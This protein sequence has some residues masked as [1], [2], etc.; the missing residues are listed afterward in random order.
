MCGVL[1]VSASGYYAWLRRGESRRGRE[2]RRLVVEIKAI[3]REKYGVYGSPRM[4]RE[5]RDRGMRHGKKRV[6]RLMRENGIM[7]KQ[8]KKF[9]AT[10]DSKHS[11]PV[12]PNLLLRNFEAETP[13]RKWLADITYIPTGEGWLYLA[14]ILDLHSR[15]LVGW[16]MSGRI[17]KELVLEA[18]QMAVG[19]RRPMSGLIHHSDRGSQYACAQY[20]RELRSQGIICSMSKTGDCWDN[21]PME[22]WFH[23]LK[24]ELVNHRDYRTRMQAKADIFEYIELFYNRSRK[25]SALGYMTPAQYEI[26]KMAA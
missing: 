11:H 24:T 2:D 26:S 1:E 18:L 8:K 25:H 5:L 21:A 22:S 6:A 7:A 13:D 19:R 15:L 10:T 12:A 23:T 4:H 20:Q 16:S 17:S 14:A 9:K 3:H